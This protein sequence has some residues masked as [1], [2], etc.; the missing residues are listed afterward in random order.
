M[1]RE[2]ILS[3]LKFWPT[4]D[5]EISD[6]R[7]KQLEEIC[8]TF[9]PIKNDAQIIR[10]LKFAGLFEQPEKKCFEA[11]LSCYETPKKLC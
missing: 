5:K 8:L 6:E 2:A 7:L 1:S 11:I 9:N 4:S 3:R 10:L